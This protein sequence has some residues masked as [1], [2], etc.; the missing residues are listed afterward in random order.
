MT[1]MMAARSACG[2]RCR[3]AM[4]DPGGFTPAYDAA[5]A[6]GLRRQGCHVLAIGPAD[7]GTAAW[8]GPRVGWFYRALPS[9]GRCTLPARAV[10]PLKG[11]HH[12]FDMARLSRGCLDRFA[13]DIVHCQWLPLPIVD[14]MVVAS[15]RRRAPL[16]L[17]VHDSTPYNG[18]AGGLMALGADA[19]ARA[20]DA[21]IVHT[22]DAQGRLLGQG[23]AANR[24]HLVPHG[25]LHAPAASEPPAPAATRPRLHLLQFGKLRPYKGVDVLL[26]ALALLSPEERL[27]LRVSVV[28]KSYIPTEPLIRFVREAALEEVV[29]FRFEFVSDEEIN[30][31]FAAADAAVFPYRQIDASGAAMTA[32]AHGVPVLASAV[33]G[34]RELF[35]DGREARLVPPGDVRALRAVVAQWLRQPE[36][37]VQLA[38]GMRQHRASVPTWPE[39]AWRT[40]EVYAAAHEVWS[41]ERGA[42]RTAVLQ[43]LPRG[44]QHE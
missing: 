34:F 8:R 30:R 42:M 12:L 4:L 11:M 20:A 24:I 43:P 25:L 15:L 40:V 32:V 31:L 27:R 44:A 28:G 36:Q 35:E 1:G 18:A 10:R 33:G 19:L 29:T 16:V 22:A 7:P 38:A 41:L 6:K 37:L 5:L 17:T 2:P 13:P 26:E 3:V 23:V 14:R 21:V 39:I 9:A